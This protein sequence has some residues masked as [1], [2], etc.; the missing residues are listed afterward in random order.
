MNGATVASLGPLGNVPSS[1]SLPLTGD[2]DG[3]LKSDLV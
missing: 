1:W 2:F 3:D